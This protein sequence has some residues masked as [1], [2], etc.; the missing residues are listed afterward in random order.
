MDYQFQ[1]SPVEP[2]VLIESESELSPSMPELLVPRGR[3]EFGSVQAEA[4]C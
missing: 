2:I 1:F 4:N 3:I